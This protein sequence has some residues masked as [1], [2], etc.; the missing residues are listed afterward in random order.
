MVLAVGVGSATVPDLGEPPPRLVKQVRIVCLALPE[1]YE[2]PA[3]V[4]TRWRI[5]KRTVAHLFNI[6]V[7]E[8][9]VPAVMFR[10]TG[11]ELE[12]LRAAGYP[13]VT[14]WKDAAMMFLGDDTDWA[15]VTELV[16]ESYCFLA[17]KKLV[18]LV[19]RPEVDGDG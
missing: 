7:G 3:W 10:S 17:P 13:Y 15:E 16:T 18:A 1:V 11:P 4:G 8:G 19:G 2:E 14:G 5:R 6:D 9:P 12:I